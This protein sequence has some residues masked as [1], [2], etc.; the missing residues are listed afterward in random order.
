MDASTLAEPAAYAW[1]QSVLPGETVGIHAAG[2]TTD[3]RVT[4][5]RIGARHEVVWSGECSLEPHAVPGDAGAN[6]CGWPVCSQPTC[7]AVS[8]G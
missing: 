3:A 8:T 5:A 7:R 1:P 4:V 6:G 2:P